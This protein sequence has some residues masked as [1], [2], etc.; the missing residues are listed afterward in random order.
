MQAA[1]VFTQATLAGHLL[2]GNGLARTIHQ[3]LG[4]EVITWVALIEI[5]LAVLAWR[6]GRG[7]AWPILVVALT[8]PAIV[9]QIAFG[10]EGRLAVHI[11]LGVTIFAVNLALLIGLR[12]PAR[13]S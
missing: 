5:V 2:S 1:L 8:L 13:T 12:R 3:Q 7:S 10:F 9:A 11:P 6:P 4:T